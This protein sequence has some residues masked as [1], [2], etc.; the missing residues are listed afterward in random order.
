MIDGSVALSW[1]RQT[2]IDGDGGEALDVPLGE[3]Q[4]RYQVRVLVGSA[5]RR[6]VIVDTPS[7]DYAAADAAA[8]GA[9][10]AVTFEVA[11]LSDRFGPGFTGKV[12]LHD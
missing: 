12:E 1:V 3:A 2:R 6:E 10:G 8:D 7:W 9:L 5:L 4:E 11:Q